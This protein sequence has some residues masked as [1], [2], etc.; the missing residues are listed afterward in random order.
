MS[1]RHGQ[2][3]H[4]PS[5]KTMR[6][7]NLGERKE[8]PYAE[9][10]G[11]AAADRTFARARPDFPNEAHVAAMERCKSRSA[12]GVENDFRVRLEKM[13]GV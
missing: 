10:I 11:A 1:T 4:T 12:T 9:R 13:H 6:Q 8:D 2:D 7:K 3:C 5:C